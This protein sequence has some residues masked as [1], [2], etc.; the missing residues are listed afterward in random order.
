M[1]GVPALA[2]AQATKNAPAQAAGA[3]AAVQA[4]Q[5]VP[6]FA[7]GTPVVIV[8]EVTSQP[9][10]AVN[11]RK[12]QVAIGPAKMDFT[13]HLSDAKLYSY[14]GSSIDENQLANKMWVRAEGKVMDDPRRVKVTRLQV[15]GKDLPGLQQ[16]AFYR[17]GFDQGYVTAVAGSREIFPTTSTAIFTPASMVIVGRVADDTGPL[18]TTRKIQVDAAGNTWTVSVPKDAPVFDTKGEK[19]SVHEIA[20]GQWIRAH[21][22]QTDDLRLRL[23]RLENIGPEQAFRTST[24][25]RA[26]EPMGYVERTPGTGVRFNPLRITGT[27][28]NV[29]QTDGTITVKDERGA[30][31]TYFIETVTVQTDGRMADPK[32]LRT[33]QR[34]TLQGSEIVF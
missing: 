30:E 19:I 9:K 1:L 15:I 17:P 32:A 20:K 5:P 33:G 6:R 26:A 25:Y 29:N 13:L 21:G 34:V 28:T 11:E 27:V 4:V 12:M 3:R 2:Q 24:Y 18:E 16:S 22:W 14:H 7:E 10:D 8:G 23:A 31:R